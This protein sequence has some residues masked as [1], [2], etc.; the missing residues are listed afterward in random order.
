MKKKEKRVNE[1]W[2]P[3]SVVFFIIIFLFVSTVAEMKK[4]TN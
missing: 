3:N 1:T 4:E 2:D